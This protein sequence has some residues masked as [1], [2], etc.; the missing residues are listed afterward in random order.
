M[1][2]FF[3]KS[4]NLWLFS[5]LNWKEA[6]CASGGPQVMGYEKYHNV[7]TVRRQNTVLQIVNR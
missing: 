1:T 5:M 6:G 4:Q 2:D 3:V 7:Q